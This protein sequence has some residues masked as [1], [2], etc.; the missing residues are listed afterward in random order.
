MGLGG[1]ARAHVSTL[2]KLHDKYALTA[3]CDIDESRLRAV[4]ENVRAKPYVDVEKM[5]NK[6][7]LDVC[8]IGVQA[9]GHHI[10]AKALAERGIHIL[11]ETPIAIT[12]SCADQMIEAARESGVLLEVSENVP[13]GLMNV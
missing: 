9:E 10:V 11:T 6:E 4:A 8:L 5:I 3:L 12:T 13:V 2:L 1:R 7:K